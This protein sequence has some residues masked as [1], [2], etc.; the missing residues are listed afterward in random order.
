MSQ[1]VSVLSAE[2][3][4]ALLSLDGLAIGDALGEMLSYQ[5]HEAARKIREDAMPAGPWFHTDDTE[6]AIAL[7][8]TLRLARSVHQDT[9]AFYFARRF[10]ADPDRGYGKMTRMQ[11]RSVLEGTPWYVASGSAFSGRGSMGN[12]SAMRVAPLGGYFAE[13]LLRVCAEARLSSEVTHRHPEGIAGAVA[14]AIAAAMAWQ[15]RDMEPELRWKTFFQSV[16]NYTPPGEVQ[17]GLEKAA[18][19][20]GASVEDAARALGNGALVTAPD[21]VP[22]AVWCAATHLRDF[23]GAVSA[24]ISGGGDC[25][26]IAAMAGGIVALSVGR[27]GIPVRWLAERERLPFDK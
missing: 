22:F 12:G 9:L 19:M 11:L 23:S 10:D 7:V 26:T 27:E 17:R 8:E 6:M 20:A 14:V 13:D 1:T 16:I 5:Y 25:D 2:L 18:G 21:S 4:R 15:T 3:E 24:A